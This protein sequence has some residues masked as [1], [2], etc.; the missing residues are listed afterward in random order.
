MRLELSL[1][2]CFL[3]ADDL[4]WDALGCAGDGAMQ[5]PSI[6]RLAAR[7]VMFRDHFVTTSI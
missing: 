4:R 5:M 6:G 1:E 3:L 2:Y 7:G